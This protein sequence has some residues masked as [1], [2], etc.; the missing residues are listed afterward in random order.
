MTNIKNFN[1]LS[2]L[3][4]ER[5]VKKRIVV[6]NPDDESTLW[7]LD[8][9]RRSGFCETII[10][11]DDDRPT[12]ARK[13][14]QLVREGKA[15]VL[16]KGFINTDVLLHAILNKEYG[17]LEPGSV[18]THITAASLP[19]YDKLIFFT[20]AAVIPYP[21][22][23]Q[24][25]Q[26]VKYLV[27]LCHSFGID[28]PRISLIHSSEKVD[29]RHFPFTEG[30]LQ[31]KAMAQN[32]DFGHCIVDGPLDVKCS[33][34]VQNM[35][36]KGINSP[37]NGEADALI[38]P[39]IEAGNSFY[40]TLTLFGRAETAGVLQGPMAPVVLPSRGDSVFSKYYSIALAAV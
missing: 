8:K 11:D 34:S 12:A 37:I 20:D 40:K 9:A 3:L 1:A 31:L 14:V 25:V 39:D 32:G 18:M 23:E 35:W 4:A 5:G 27:N 22:Q 6:V 10:V 30:Y 29:A 19:A 7:A 17:I 33:C 24:R 36:A 26:Q 2:I 21:T 15:D 16:M 28:V 38:F 13:A